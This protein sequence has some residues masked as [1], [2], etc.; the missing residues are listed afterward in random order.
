MIISHDV[1]P[2]E[3]QNLDYTTANDNDDTLI[4][5]TVVSATSAR[6]AKVVGALT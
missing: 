5:V 1:F 6:V 3:L 4:V 2:T